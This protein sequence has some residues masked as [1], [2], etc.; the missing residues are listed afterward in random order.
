MCH[1]PISVHFNGKYKYC[2][3]YMYYTSCYFQE[4]AGESVLIFNCSLWPCKVNEKKKFSNKDLLLFFSQVADGTLSNLQNFT[5]VSQGTTPI[6][7]GAGQIVQASNIVQQANNLMVQGT[8][9]VS[10][11]QMTPA[12]GVPQ[13]LFLNQVTV[14][15]QTSFVL[16]DANNKP[17]Q[18][19][20]G[21][22]WY[23]NFSC[24]L[25][26]EKIT[27]TLLYSQYDVFWDKLGFYLCV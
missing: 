18:L 22:Y 11:A 25:S 14:N 13:M 1:L 2:V 19:P 5:S 21:L 24:I 27:R 8:P 17:V 10:S 16:V 3:L 23:Q 6:V 26:N 4:N 9:Q 15:G 12:V 20:Q 7:S